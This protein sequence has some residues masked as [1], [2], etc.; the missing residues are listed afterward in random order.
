MGNP[1]PKR[2]QQQ[3]KREQRQSALFEP[4]PHEGEETEGHAN[5]KDQAEADMLKSVYEKLFQGKSAVWTAI[6]TCAL[7]L[8]S[9]LLY[10]VNR[11]ANDTSIATQRA[12]ITYGG[13]GPIEKITKDGSPT[14]PL[15]A[16]GIH[17]PMVNS[18]T[19]ATKYS[20]SELSA[21]VG[22]LIPNN[23]TDFESL[24]HSERNRF[25]WG[26]RQAWDGQPLILSLDDMNAVEQKKKHIFLWGWVVYRDIFDGTPIHLSEFCTEITD[27]KWT[28]PD[29]IDVT[30]DL[31]V[32]TMPCPT[33][34]CYDQDCAD[35]TARI[36]DAK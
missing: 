18:G 22:D 6:F 26:P 34:N 17:I 21:S 32:N 16:Y 28:K 24:P 11:Q 12:F 2:K 30:G 29:H 31:R 33:H 15:T 20:I 7:C 23:G 13:V 25:L 19:T 4:M 10:E 14:G 27:P 9:F 1:A 8:F 36:R 5:Q 35:Y 3:R